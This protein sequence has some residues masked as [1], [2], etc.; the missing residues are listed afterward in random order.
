M[1]AIY[2]VAV[3]VSDTHIPPLLELQWLGCHADSY[4]WTDDF[5]WKFPEFSTTEG[6]HV[7][8]QANV[9]IFENVGSSVPRCCRLLTTLD[10]IA[11]QS[12]AVHGFVYN[13]R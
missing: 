13:Q 1:S 3:R 9:T 10:M 8:L 6:G 2:P 5:V 4:S 7:D 12:F 11:P